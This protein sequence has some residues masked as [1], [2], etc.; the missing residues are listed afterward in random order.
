MSE[1]YRQL[2]AEELREKARKSA[3]SA[4]KKGRRYEPLVV[5]STGRKLCTSWWG[6]AWCDNLES[7]SDYFN[8]LPR[9][10]RYVRSGAVI[11]LVISEGVVKAKVQGSRVKPY[12][13]TI[14]IDPLPEKS[15]KI[16]EERCISGIQSLEDLMAGKFPKDMQDLF[17]SQD[18]L[19]PS[20]SQIHF[21]CSC[22]DWAYM[23]KHVAAVMYGIGVKLDENP[24]LFF[25]LRQINPEKLVQKAVANKLEAM[26]ENADRPSKRIL[27]ED[28]D[29]LFGL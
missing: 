7:Y 5:Q 10:K 14:K 4:S 20:P 2:S 18:G 8:R 19:F 27:K 21:D 25:E 12:T 29:Q 15:R 24:F 17:R 28:P 11:D 9:G 22:P 16:I 6:Q 23:C 26:L 3:A 13:V 1:Y